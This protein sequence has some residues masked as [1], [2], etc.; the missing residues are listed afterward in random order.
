MRIIILL[1]LLI[2]A[3]VSLISR[4]VQLKTGFYKIVDK[5]SCTNKKGY[6][7]IND[8]GTDYCIS[9]TP[10]ITDA[11]FES[12]N[13]TKDTTENGV[14]YAVS[15]KLDSAGT[16]IIKDATGKMVGQKTAF[17]INNKIVAAPTVRDPITSG[18]IAVFCDD[19]TI[20]K[21]KEA[22]KVK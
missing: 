8:S 3:S 5:D 17:I 14:T 6:I 2:F 9:Q 4:E 11:N 1:L 21:V 16:Q 15:I 12:V 18:R 13:I 10:M 20:D 7:V 22:L 19:E